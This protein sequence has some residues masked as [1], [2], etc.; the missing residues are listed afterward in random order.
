MLTRESQAL[1]AGTDYFPEE[2]EYDIGD[3]VIIIDKNH[4]FHGEAARIIGIQRSVYDILQAPGS[5]GFH[6]EN[7]HAVIV[8]RCQD[9][10][11]TEL[12]LSVKQVKKLENR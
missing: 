4:P 12:I 8:D 1:N 7:L 2:T 10:H 6:D 3:Y 5:P 9:V 11:Q